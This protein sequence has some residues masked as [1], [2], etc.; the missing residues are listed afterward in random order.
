VTHETK[1]ARNFKTSDKGQGA[2]ERRRGEKV[3]IFENMWSRGRAGINTIKVRR[4]SEKS[5][6]DVQNKKN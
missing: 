2:E 6:G 5:K 1:E 3:T 4:I